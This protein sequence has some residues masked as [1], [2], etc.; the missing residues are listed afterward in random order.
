MI[1]CLAIAML[2]GAAGAADVSISQEALDRLISDLRA[3]QTA[4][5]NQPPDAAGRARWL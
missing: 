5:A 4:A 2:A 1:R 3:V